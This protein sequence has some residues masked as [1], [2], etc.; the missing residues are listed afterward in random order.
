MFDVESHCV[1]KTAFRL[2]MELKVAS[3]FVCI[4]FGLPNSGIAGLC[5]HAQLNLF[6]NVELGSG[7][8]IQN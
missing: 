8:N 2:C 7:F 1:A 4:H 6:F 3:G 5:Q